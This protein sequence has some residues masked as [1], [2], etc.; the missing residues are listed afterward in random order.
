MEVEIEIEIEIKTTTKYQLNKTNKKGYSLAVG[1]CIS[2][3][4]VVVIEGVGTED[5]SWSSL[6]F[7]P[8]AFSGIEV[9]MSWVTNNHLSFGF[10]SLSFVLLSYTYLCTVKITSSFIN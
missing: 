5:D 1:K 2:G 6:V 4:S 7:I 3:W 9:M 8:V 10:S